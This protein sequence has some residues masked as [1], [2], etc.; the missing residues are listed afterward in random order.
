MMTIKE[1]SDAVAAR[2][3]GSDNGLGSQIS[4]DKATRKWRR[5]RLTVTLSSIE[6]RAQ[7]TYIA[8]DVGGPMGHTSSSLL[9]HALD[10]NQVDLVAKEVVS[11]V[12]NRFLYE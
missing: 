6:G 9:P 11:L 10:Q 4:Y 12:T 5:G 2:V 8:A 7:I 1:F 3:R